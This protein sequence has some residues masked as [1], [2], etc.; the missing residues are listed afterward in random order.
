[1]A[2]ACVDDPVGN[3]KY[4]DTQAG[5]DGLDAAGFRRLGA[6]A[7][8]PLQEGGYLINIKASTV[9]ALLDSNLEI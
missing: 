8:L 3:K 4:L 9:P 2:H 7:P 5:N 1:M 6:A